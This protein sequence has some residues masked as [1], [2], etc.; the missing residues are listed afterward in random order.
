MLLSLL[1]EGKLAPISAAKTGNVFD[2][3]GD[4]WIWEMTSPSAIIGV[5]Y[6]ISISATTQLLYI[7]LSY[8]G[9]SAGATAFNSLYCCSRTFS[10]LWYSLYNSWYIKSCFWINPFFKLLISILRIWS[11]FVNLF[12]SCFNFEFLSF[13]NSTFSLIWNASSRMS[14]RFYF[15]LSLCS[16]KISIRSQDSYILKNPVLSLINFTTSS[17]DIFFLFFKILRRSLKSSKLCA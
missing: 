16:S 17:G 4:C 5:Y 6:I 14:L 3:C 15:N 1:I 13:S 10:L 7:L 12:I 2:L 11:C 9:R 8:N